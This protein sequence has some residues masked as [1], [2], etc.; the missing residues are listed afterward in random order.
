MEQFI[1]NSDVP[2]L[3]TVYFRYH[4]SGLHCQ[5][6]NYVLFCSN[7]NLQ[8]N[9]KIFYIICNFNFISICIQEQFP[10]LRI[11]RCPDIYPLVRLP[12]SPFSTWQRE[13]PYSA[14]L[15]VISHVSRLSVAHSLPLADVGRSTRHLQLTD[16]NNNYYYSYLYSYYNN[17][18]YYYSHCYYYYYYHPV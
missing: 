4:Y 1:L 14:I 10:I 2:E 12:I 17:N 16:N 8:I 5:K 9:K 6:R 7:I 11:R 3:E 13:N 15:L 18:Y